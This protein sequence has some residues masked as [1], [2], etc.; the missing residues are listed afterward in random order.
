MAPKT[1]KGKGRMTAAEKKKKFE[2]MQEMEG[3]LEAEEVAAEAAKGRQQKAKSGKAAE[4]KRSFKQELTRAA[5]SS[6]HP[7]PSS[8]EDQPQPKCK[9]PTIVVRMP[10]GSPPVFVTDEQ[11]HALQWADWCANLP[12]GIPELYKLQQRWTQQQVRSEE[13]QESS[14]DDGHEADVSEEKQES[15]YDDGNEADDEDT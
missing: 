6:Q 12:P 1:P 5:P 9:K 4:C 2:Q 13:K 15:S 8:S 14:D 11:Q 10:S 3:H 7:A